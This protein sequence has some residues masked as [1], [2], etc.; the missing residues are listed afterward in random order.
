MNKIRKSE[1]G[2]ALVLVVLAIVGLIGITAVSVDGG[3]AYLDRRNAQNAADAAALATALTKIRGGDWHASGLARAASNGYDNNNTSNIVN[4]YQCTNNLANCGIYQGN[5]EYYQVIIISHLKTLFAPVVGVREVTN[6]VNAIARARPGHP[7]PMGAG[8]AVFTL[9][10]T[11]CQS[12]V[13]Q[14]S[15]E[16]HL[17]GSG[18]YVNS[19][20]P[21]SAFKNQSGP[22]MFVDTCPALQ[23]VGG[24]Q[25]GS[26]VHGTPDTASC[27]QTNVEPQ[28]EPILPNFDCDAMPTA[29]IQTDGHTL[30]R[31]N[32]TGAF[33]PNGV[34]DLQSGVY[35]VHNGNFSVNAGQTLLGNEVVLYIID[36]AVT[37]NGQARIDLRAPTSGDYKGLLMYLPP[38]NDKTVSISGGGQITM[39]GSILA[40]SSLIRVNGGGDASAPLNTQ[41]VGKDVSFLGNATIKITYIEEQQYHPPI[42]P[43]LQ[44]A[45]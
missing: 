37:L 3:L 13:Y 20:C 15:A 41:L 25:G 28:P 1:R 36:G 4:I 2:Q 24:I 6:Q 40:P 34:T 44:L 29:T 30:S 19:T 14:A 35:C 8:S 16:V 31:G 26:A 32:W 10:K 43:S 42:P 21:D 39:V 33:P 38:T 23:V 9:N 5:V 22:G 17:Y 7:M 18:I 27:K 12:A 45:R 11:G